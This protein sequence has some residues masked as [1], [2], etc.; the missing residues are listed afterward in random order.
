MTDTLATL[1]KLLAAIRANPDDDT[2]RLV[3]ADALE[4]RGELARAMLIRLQCR[5]AVLP[6]W[7]R[8]AADA[9]REVARLLADH[10]AAW[11]A[12]L[13]ALDGVAWTTF[14][15]G[16]V[17]GAR[18]DTV[19][20]LYQHAGALRDAAPI[21]RVE[22]AVFDETDSARPPDGLPW[23]RGLRITRTWRHFHVAQRR[24]LAAVPTELE[25][26]LPNG[27]GPQEL[28]AARGD[29][30]LH[31]L[32]LVGEHTG[33]VE[34]VAQLAQTPG[35]M[36]LRELVVGTKFVDHDTGYYDDPTLRVA[37]AERLARAK[38]DRIEVLDVSRQRVED[39]GLVA[40]VG[41]LP[42]L[43]RLVARSCEVV[44][45]DWLL[46][47][48]GTPLATLDLG[49][50][51]IGDA[52]ARAIAG[53]PRL[54]QLASLELDTCEISGA[55]VQALVE[56]P[57]WQT[58]RVLDLSRN[59]LGVDGA[60][61]LAGAPRP[62]HLHAL[63]LAD[64]DLDGDAARLLATTPWLHQ[65]TAVDLSRN[66]VTGELVA[67]LRDVR[68]LRLADAKP[69]DDVRAALAAACER[70][71]RLDLGGVALGDTVALPDRAPELYRLDIGGCRID[72]AAAARLG[73]A[74]YPHLRRLELGPGTLGDA[75]LAALLESPLA[76]QLHALG[77]ANT[78]LAARS[79][80]RLFDLALPRLAVLD[81]SLN[82]FDEPTLLA[83]ARSPALRRVPV[84][85][86]HG[87]GWPRTAGGRDE[88]TKRFGGGWYG[89]TRAS[90]DPE[91][92][93]DARADPRADDDDDE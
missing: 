4:E 55:A 59:P 54:A 27:G 25:L 80:S 49:G 69:V 89:A 77:L 84:V 52:G 87:T 56:S 45:L 72:R 10:G 92:A 21:E 30:P 37:G 1:D 66:A 64:A 23:L 6:P 51:T 12:E 15:R 88:L 65:L 91:F 85:V 78:A 68:D 47:D 38:L 93:D 53:A 82:A 5:L 71:W 63:A 41:S 79:V 61:A 42:R 17:D 58:L 76:A 11:R 67:A 50:N 46:A 75:E 39:D 86:L 18:V 31:K 60:L 81:L 43:R 74:D 9:R 48:A 14:A 22:L 40:L 26:V 16:F 57:L 13:P 90:L 35:A 2:P 62:R 70:A 83:I 73:R 20:E 24:S 28:I 3:Y 8:E 7:E 36:A 29:Q 33:A 34:A 19:P 44:D 32:V